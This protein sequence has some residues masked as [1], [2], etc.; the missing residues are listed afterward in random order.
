MDIRW[1]K[2]A[3]Q[4]YKDEDIRLIRKT[5]PDG[6]TITL[7]FVMLL[8]LAGDRNQGGDVPYTDEELAV[9]FD[10]QINTVRL[11]LRV[12]LEKGMIDNLDGIIHISNWDK[13]QSVDEMDKIREQNRR[14]KQEERNR[15]KAIGAG[16]VPSLP[17]KGFAPE[18]ELLAIQG[19]HNTVLD[20]AE[21]V[22]FPNDTYTM[23]K[24]IG[25]YGK[26]GLEAVL[27]GIDAC[28]MSGVKTLRYLE[29]CLKKTEQEKKQKTGQA[30]GSQ[31]YDDQGREIWDEY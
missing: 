9:L 15:K 14:R 11:G 19:E 21:R 2:L 22:G 10:I 20:A 29:G 7:M 27:A 1:I 4:F 25:F 23:D 16:D 30:S 26:Y 17:A 28:G 8:A 5:L 12:M 13:Y 6:D 31:R 24:L 3:V 18:E